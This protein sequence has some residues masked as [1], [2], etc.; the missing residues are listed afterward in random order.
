MKNRKTLTGIMINFM[1]VIMGLYIQDE[2]LDY[3]DLAERENV[4]ERTIY[5]DASDACKMLAPYLFG[6]DAII[7]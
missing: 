4:V 7:N 2:K 5:R 1:I 3:A 6:V